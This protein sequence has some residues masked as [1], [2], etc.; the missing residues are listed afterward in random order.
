MQEIRPA[1]FNFFPQHFSIMC[2]LVTLTACV[3]HA[4]FLRPGTKNGARHVRA[5]Q[6]YCMLCCRSAQGGQAGSRHGLAHPAAL[7]IGDVQL[8]LLRQAGGLPE[9]LGLIISVRQ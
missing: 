2:L 5:P 9:A 4:N 3:T 7:L 8:N 6:G 1:D